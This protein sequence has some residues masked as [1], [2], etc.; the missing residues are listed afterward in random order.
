VS[1]DFLS[2]ERI[3][4]GGIRKMAESK[5][6]VIRLMTDED[7]AAWVKRLIDEHP[8]DDGFWVFGYGSLIWNPAFHFAER[9]RCRVHGYR[10]SFCMWTLLGRGSEELPGL[11]LG[12]EHGGSCTGVVYRIDPEILEVELDIILRRE[13]MSYTYI[14][15]WVK[16]ECEGR[17]VKA[18]TFVMDREHERYVCNEPE[19]KM[20]RHLATASGP[21]G[22][23]CDYLFDLTENLTKLDFTDHKLTRLEKKV[24]EYQKAHDIDCD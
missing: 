2:R 18:I 16:A 8:E 7:R 4:E 20:V 13:L 10:R 9:E 1:R 14:P 6:G 23:N 17:T 19:E 5:P 3:L 21:L 15:T 24:R 11:M 22:R 12:L